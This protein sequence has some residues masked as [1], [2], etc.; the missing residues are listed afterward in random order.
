MTRGSVCTGHAYS[1]C[2]AASRRVAFVVSPAATAPFFAATSPSG[3]SP[4]RRSIICTVCC[5]ALDVIRI[6]RRRGKIAPG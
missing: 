6:S 5:I 3:R 2:V 4:A 1:T